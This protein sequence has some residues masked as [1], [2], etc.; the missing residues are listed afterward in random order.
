[1]SDH[2]VITSNQ[3]GEQDYALPSGG[4]ATRTPRG[5][6]YLRGKG[7]NVPDFT[8]DDILGLAAVIRALH[9]GWRP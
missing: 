6:W 7:G 1:M 3:H 2:K 9:Q 4:L 5:Y 8:D